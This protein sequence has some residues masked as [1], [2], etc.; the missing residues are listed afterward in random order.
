MNCYILYQTDITN[1]ELLDGVGTNKGSGSIDSAD[2]TD[3]ETFG[4]EDNDDNAGDVDIRGWH[5]GDEDIDDNAGDV[6]IRDEEDE[7]GFRLNELVDCLFRFNL[8]LETSRSQECER[9]LS[10]DILW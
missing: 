9:I 8:D 7:D 1:K 4:D 5:V 10:R 2:S 6:D 3:E